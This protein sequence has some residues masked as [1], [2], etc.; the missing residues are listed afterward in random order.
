MTNE[1]GRKERIMDTAK[2]FAIAYKA[3]GCYTCPFLGNQILGL[4]QRCDGKS[5]WCY[6]D[7]LAK[8]V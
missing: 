3:N 2:V 5:D 8:G 1:E 7:A 6:W 4:E